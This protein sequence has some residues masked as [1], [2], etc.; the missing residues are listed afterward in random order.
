[1][2]RRA[3]ITARGSYWLFG[4]FQHGRR[5][6]PRAEAIGRAAAQGPALRDDADTHCFFP[7]WRAGAS[8][9]LLH[10]RARAADRSILAREKNAARQRHF[11]I[12]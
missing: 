2:P 9:W 8:D 1:M 3:D 11:A 6:M 5:R 12:T 10:R 4:R 7:A